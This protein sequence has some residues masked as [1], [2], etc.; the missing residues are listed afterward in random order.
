MA[1]I[2]SAIAK[3]TCGPIDTDTNPATLIVVIVRQEGSPAIPVSDS[4]GNTWIE[5][6]KAFSAN[7]GLGVRA[8]YCI[9]PNTSATHTFTNGV[10]AGYIIG[11]IA[12][13]NTGISFDQSAG[14]GTTSG[15]SHTSVA[16][17]ALTPNQAES[18]VVTGAFA[19]AVSA[20]VNSMSAGAGWTPGEYLD[21]PSADLDVAFSFKELSAADPTGV[22]WTW[23]SAGEGAATVVIFAADNSGGG[24]GGLAMPPRRAFPMSI[25]NH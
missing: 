24:G 13:D 5:L 18:I 2:A 9:N 6:P 3:T 8:Y 7:F 11:A 16:V 15:T 4:E 25:L 12:F 17:G 19:F 20:D 22:T 14:Q 23:N 1:K 10:G 21:T